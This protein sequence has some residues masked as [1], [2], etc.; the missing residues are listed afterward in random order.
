MS[1]NLFCLNCFN[2]NKPINMPEN[3]Q[4]LGG[5]CSN[6]HFRCIAC[7]YAALDIPSTYKD[8]TG[9]T[10]LR[11]GVLAPKLKKCPKGHNPTVSKVN[12]LGAWEYVCYG[13]NIKKFF[14]DEHGVGIC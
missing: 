7:S 5:I 2:Q 14:D 13:C 12:T 8:P 4:A 3:Y 10:Y 6:G 1:G 11:E 9:D